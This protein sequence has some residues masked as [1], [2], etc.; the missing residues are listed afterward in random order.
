[1]KSFNGNLFFCD[2]TKELA[3]RF[4][5]ENEKH[6]NVVENWK[7]QKLLWNS[8]SIISYVVA[9]RRFGRRDFSG[10]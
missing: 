10:R 4:F 5:A 7:A 6:V 9:A 2:F 3:K 1:M 8:L